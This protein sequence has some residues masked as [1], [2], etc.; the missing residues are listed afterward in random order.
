MATITFD[1][2]T[3]M[4]TLKAAGVP[5]AQARAHAVAM[6]EALRET[7]ATK[8]DIT[9]LRNAIELMRRDPI[10]RLGGMIVALGG[11]LV[12]IKYFG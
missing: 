2:L 11:I 1:R 12:T 6:D 5:E 9:E 7:V 8:A 4:E 3:Y 10:I